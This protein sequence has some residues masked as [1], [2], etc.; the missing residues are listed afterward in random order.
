MS[1]LKQM[2]NKRDATENELID[3][4]KE[5]RRFLWLKPFV[6]WLQSKH[7]KGEEK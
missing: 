7:P 3:L 6:E 4:I 5:D 1:N 2:E